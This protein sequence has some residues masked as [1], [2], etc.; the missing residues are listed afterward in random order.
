MPWWIK[1]FGYGML[2]LGLLFTLLGM[3]QAGCLPERKG[4]DRVLRYS[5]GIRLACLCFVLAV[6]PLWIDA[7]FLM[8]KPV[9]ERLGAAAIFAVFFGPLL[10]ETFGRKVVVTPDIISR[11]YFGRL[12]FERKRSE[13]TDVTVSDR[14]GIC[15]V[16]FKDGAKLRISTGV[17]GVYHIVDEFGKV[18][19]A[20]HAEAARTFLPNASQ[21]SP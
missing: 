5:S 15:R 18:I 16:H 21:G 12:V 6:M 7:T 14:Q 2:A 17:M 19:R 1:L 13:I 20:K 11:S 3:G 8:H 9:L 10:L 4:N